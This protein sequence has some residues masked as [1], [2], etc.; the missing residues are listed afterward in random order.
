MEEI[1]ELLSCLVTMFSASEKSKY[2]EGIDQEEEMAKEKVRTLLAFI[3]FSGVVAIVVSLMVFKPKHIVKEIAV[4]EAKHIIVNQEKKVL[5]K[6][7]PRLNINETKHGVN[8][9]TI[10]ENTKNIEEKH[11]LFAKMKEKLAH[12]I[13]EKQNNV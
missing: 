3:L 13:E 4:A 5:G 12:K 7:D 9:V 2:G 10:N 8:S 1:I 6:I 11:P